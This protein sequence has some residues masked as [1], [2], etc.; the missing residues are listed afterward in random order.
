MNTPARPPAP[1]RRRLRVRTLR[2]RVTIVAS[3]VITALVVLGI[4]LLYLL[5]R[6]SIRADIDSQLRT[7]STEIAQTGTAGTWPSTLPPSTLDANAEAQVLGADGR[8]LAASHALTGA[9]ALYLLPAGSSQPVRQPA[10][11]RVLTG[12]VR[13]LAVPATVHATPVTIV[14]VTTT[15]LLTMLDTEAAGRLLTAIPITLLLA[16]GAVWLIVGRALKPVERIRS[17]VTEIT[18]VDLTRR[19][20]EPGTDD[21]IRRLA[22]TMNDMLDRLDAAAR[23]QRRFVA[24]ASHELRSPLAAIRTTLEVALAHPDKAPWPEIGARAADQTIRLEELLHQLL[25][26]AKADEGELLTHRRPVDVG[27]L[28]DGIHATLAPHAVEVTVHIGPE[29]VAAGDP[30]QLQRLFRNIIDNATR[31]AA[32]HV[33]VSGHRAGERLVV[34]VDDDGPGIPLADRERVFDRFV[35]LDT[36]RD[37]ASGSTGLGLAI[38]REIARAHGGTIAVTDAPDGGARVSVELPATTTESVL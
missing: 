14:T 18:S 6:E 23:R 3:L 37:R 35:R 8:V 5:Q 16:A 36:S 24:D 17:A 33:D 27:E 1:H 7:Y 15:G 26:L 38:A 20:P 2:A 21:E 25:T 22:H 13:V 11:D 19:V 30:S 29:L 10:A 4:A 31:H 9:G 28:L 32:H 34:H 12:E